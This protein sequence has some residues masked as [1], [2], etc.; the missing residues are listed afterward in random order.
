MRL[1]Q[2]KL[3]ALLA[4]LC[5]GAASPGA[6]AAPSIKELSRQAD[7]VFRGTIVKAGAANLEIVEPNAKTAVVRVDEVLKAS[8]TL[9]DFTGREVT[10]FLRGRAV[11]AGAQRVFFTTVG[12]LGESLGVQEVGRLAGRAV[13]AKSRLQAVERE[14]LEEDLKARL[15]EADLAI[16]G[17]VLS[18]RATYDET[19][20]GVIS[21]HDPLWWEAVF[22]VKAV[23]RGQ[24]V[25]AT[26]PAWFPASRDVL[27]ASVPKPRAGHEGTWLLHRYQAEDG[28]FI[29][30]ILSPQ[31]LLS[32]DE[33]K[34]AEKMVKP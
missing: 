22:E 12:L 10:V 33:A 31:D 11:K 21:E 34:L 2:A 30:T 6:E 5:W 27:W 18:A 14:L 7:F 20:L 28:R 16:M 4:A 8:A 26:V 32:A 19:H 9:D 3:A 29:Y 1:K 17:R 25:E 13:E 15:D 24:W 23:L